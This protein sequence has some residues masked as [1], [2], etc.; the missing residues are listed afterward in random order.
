MRGLRQIRLSI[1]TNKPILDIAGVGMRAGAPE[2]DNAVALV[3]E[4]AVTSG[5]VLAKPGR[6]AAGTLAGLHRLERAL[7]L[8]QGSDGSAFRWDSAGPVAHSE[9]RFRTL[10]GLPTLT[11]PGAGLQAGS[12][13]RLR[14]GLQALLKGL[15]LA[16]KS[17]AALGGLFA[18]HVAHLRRIVGVPFDGAVHQVGFLAHQ[19]R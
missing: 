19:F 17:L 2:L 12:G 9:L 8:L 1:A 4:L 15:L 14:G 11:E 13:H 5:G 6:S 10:H 18:R 7:G 3:A 16:S